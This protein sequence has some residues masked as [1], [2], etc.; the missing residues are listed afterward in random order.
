MYIN[1]HAYATCNYEVFIHSV[2]VCMCQAN[3]VNIYQLNCQST[4]CRFFLP[5]LCNASCFCGGFSCRRIRAR[6]VFRV[7]WKRFSGRLQRYLGVGC[8]TA[9]METRKILKQKKKNGAGW[10]SRLTKL[11]IEL[12]LRSTRQC[13]F[14]CQIRSLLS[15][16]RPFAR[17]SNGKSL[18][19]K[20]L[21]RETENKEETLLCD[22]K[23]T[24]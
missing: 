2:V 18:V 10:E 21:L 12:I 11:L 16:G 4:E 5:S 3:V 9:I 15:V 6:T 17:Y 23:Y 14:N 1:V 22:I 20:N 24:R 7:G 8:E 19:A 13:F